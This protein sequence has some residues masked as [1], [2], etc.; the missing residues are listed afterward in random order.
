MSDAGQRL[1]DKAGRGKFALSIRARLMILAVIAI[2]PLLFDRIRDIESDRAER[3]EAASKQ[4]LNLARQGM[5]AQNEAIVSV[6]AF[7]QVAASAHGL[8]ATRGQRCDDFLTDAVRQVP[9]L[10]NMSLLEPGGRVVCSSNPD[11]IGADLS[12]APHFIRAMRTGEFTLSDYYV[13]QRVGPTLLTALPHRGPTGSIDVVVTGPLELSWFTEVARSLA[14]SF[15]AVVM[16]VDGKGTLL[17]RQPSRESWVG[18]PFADHPMI[19][20][21]LASPEG[22]FTGESLDGVRRVFAFVELPG[23]G[24]RLA[25]GFDESDILR[26]VNRELLVSVGGLGLITAIVLI[27]IWF[28][29]ERFFVEPIRALTRTAQRF[30]RGEYNVRAA[31]TARVAEFIPLA[32]ALDD[33]AAR[34]AAREQELRDANGQLRE[35]V[36]IDALTGI[37]NRRA[38]NAR[39]AAE[40]QLAAELGQPL[41]V[42]IVDVDHFK[43]FNDCYGHLQ[44]DSCLRRFSEVLTASTRI[45]SDAAPHTMGAAL[46]PSFRNFVGRESDF[47]ARYGGE[48]FALLLQ[49]ASLDA[50]V[51]VAERL[52]RAV[53]ELRIVHDQAPIGIVTISVGVASLTPGKGESAQRLLE[54]ADAGL[55]DAKRRGRNLVVAHAGL[56]L[57][58]AS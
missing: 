21:M 46:P 56:A 54:L 34:L 15:D 11:A 10:K 19:R 30:G 47:A 58:K 42:L 32:A 4:A 2:V 17:T 27:G 16:M 13:G 20:A 8:M 12:H 18:R 1:E 7:L 36:D 48:E 6:R 3:I 52:R 53:E 50:A 24:A 40:W 43:L 49:G 33:M 35:L 39:L 38:F 45:R 41:A 31:E 51:K 22:V 44:G 37:A 28:G 23:T 9:W 57:S 5:A 55:Y 26:R 25:V 29:G 14:V